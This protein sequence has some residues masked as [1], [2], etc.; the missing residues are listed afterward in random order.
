MRLLAF[1]TTGYKFV[2]CNGDSKIHFCI[3]IGWLVKPVYHYR[4]NETSSHFQLVS[5]WETG[6][7]YCYGLFFIFQGLNLFLVG[8]RGM[9]LK[10][11][12][13]RTLIIFLL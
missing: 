13:L 6:T 11:L 9:R 8:H 3:S 1:L 4:D 5:A 2:L 10:C 7:E 12:D